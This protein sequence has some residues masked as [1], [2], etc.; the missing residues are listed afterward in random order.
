MALGGWGKG[1]AAGE[2]RTRLGV[3]GV[4]KA[5]HQLGEYTGAVLQRLKARN[6]NVK[7]TVQY[8]RHVIS[9]ADRV[10]LTVEDAQPQG[11]GLSCGGASKMQSLNSWEGPRR[12]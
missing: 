3:Y 8:R 5:A 4:G 1:Q 9:K 12:E 10:R 6:L 2:S 7:V 11:S